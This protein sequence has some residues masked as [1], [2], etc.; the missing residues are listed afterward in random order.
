MSTQYAGALIIDGQGA[1]LPEH[2]IMVTEG[3]IE[4][5]AP[6]GTFDGFAGET[7]RLD[8]ATVLPGLIDCHIHTLYGAEPNPGLALECMDPGRI[9]VRGLMNARDTLAGGIT[10]VRDCGGQDYSSSRFETPATPAI[11]MAPRY[12]RPD[13]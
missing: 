1:C 4:N 13:A 10:A 5:V 12:G 11:S 6:S 3:R 7:I 8:D 2:A 9:V